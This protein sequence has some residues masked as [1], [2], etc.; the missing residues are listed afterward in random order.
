MLAG[1]K[2]IGTVLCNSS[3]YA[4]TPVLVNKVDG[5][6]A[7]SGFLN[8]PSECRTYPNTV[9]FL[10]RHPESQGAAFDGTVMLYGADRT[11]RD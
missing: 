4:D 9:V 7:F 1:S 11:I 5:A 10:I 2:L 6:L 8:L 3:V